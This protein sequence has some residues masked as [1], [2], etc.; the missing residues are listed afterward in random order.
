M[1]SVFFH[2]ESSLET[3]FKKKK[4][5][6][7][8]SLPKAARGNWIHRHVGAS[9][10]P[11]SG[12]SR[13]AGGDLRVCLGSKSF[14]FQLWAEAQSRGVHD[15]SLGDGSPLNL[16]EGPPLPRAGRL[17]G[18]GGAGSSRPVLARGRG[19][20]PPSDVAAGRGAGERGVAA[21]GGGPGVFFHV[22]KRRR[23]PGLA[24]RRPSSVRPRRLRAA[25]P[26]L[27]AA[28]DGG[29]GPELAAPATAA[30]PAPALG[31]G[32][33]GPRGGPGPGL[34]HRT[35]DRGALR[36]RRVSAHRA[37][38]R[39]RA[40]PLRGDVS[41]RPEVR[42]QVP[43]PARPAPVWRLQRPLSRFPLSGKAFPSRRTSP[44]PAQRTRAPPSRSFYPQ[45]SPTLN[46]SAGLRGRASRFF[47]SSGPPAWGWNL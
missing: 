40:L 10:G 35:A 42:L 29:Q 8:S 15:F 13:G 44:S 2:V 6:K 3:K 23:A 47:C 16:P 45:T 11:K 4:K 19:S 12:E 33:G 34:R 43:R 27:L 30:A 22:C 7:F 26:P 21:A 9:T 46:L 18:P 24:P 17:T 39:L 28:P 36:A 31:D 5:K 1:V 38:W 37:Q 20:S 32:A 41:R 14:L 25:P